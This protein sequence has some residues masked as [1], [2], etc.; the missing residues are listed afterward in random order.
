MAANPI[1]DQLDKIMQQV[2]TARSQA[3]GAGT[4]TPTR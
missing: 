4:I 1:L 3:Q 2:N